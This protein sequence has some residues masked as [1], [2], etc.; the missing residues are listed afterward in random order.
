VVVRI[1]TRGSD[2]ALVQANYIARRV[3]ETLAVETEL[4]VITTTGDRVQDTPLAEIGGKGLFVKEIEHALLEGRADLAVH[5]AKDLPAA[6]APGLALVAFPERGDP[7]DALVGRSTSDS[8]MGLRQGARVGTGSVRRRALLL[9]VRPDLEIVP[10]RGNVPTRLAKIESLELDAVVL[11]SAG[12]HRLGLASRVSELITPDTMLPAVC[13]GTLALEAREGESL[14][15]DLAALDDPSTATSV[16]AERAFQ[17][18]LEGD[19]GVPLAAYC[20]LVAGGRI[21]LRGL[22]ASPDG[23]RVVRAESKSAAEHAAQMGRVLGGELLAA[24]AEEILASLKPRSEEGAQLSL[25]SDDVGELAPDP[26]PPAGT[27]P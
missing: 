5:S 16:S 15:A 10:L 25:Q 6:M 17:A 9:A 13:Q 4:V 26:G 27:K 12:L 7:R 8:L 23:T 20:E 22:V 2:L 3:R 18:E 21:R 14:A 11:A 19:C 1:A 24:G